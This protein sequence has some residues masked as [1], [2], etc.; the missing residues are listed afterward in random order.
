MVEKS[1]ETNPV[2]L[3]IDF[4]TREHKVIS[5]FDKDNINSY[6]YG[7]NQEVFRFKFKQLIRDP[8]IWEEMQNYY[9]VEKFTTEEELFFY[10]KYFD[11]IRDCGCGYAAATNTLSNYLKEKKKIFMKSLAFQCIK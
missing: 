2:Y 5:I 7:A 8:Y 6:Q 10:E 4:E 1:D 11:I 3:K 9:P